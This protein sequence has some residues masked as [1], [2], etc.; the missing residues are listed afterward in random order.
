MI[1]ETYINNLFDY[2]HTSDA[3]M[4][5][6]FQKLRNFLIYTTETTNQFVDEKL[7]QQMST[8]STSLNDLLFLLTKNLMSTHTDKLK[9]TLEC[10]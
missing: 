1:D 2:M 3:I 6:D 5:D 9:Q 8:L 10:A 4:W 7:K